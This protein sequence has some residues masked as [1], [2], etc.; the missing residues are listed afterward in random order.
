M[1]ENVNL[2]SSLRMIDFRFFHLPENSQFTFF[3]EEM[4]NYIM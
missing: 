3:S 2:S 1:M 4:K